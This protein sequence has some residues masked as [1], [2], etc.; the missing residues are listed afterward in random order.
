MRPFLCTARPSIHT[1]PTVVVGRGASHGVPACVCAQAAGA[2]FMGTPSQP[3]SGALE[4]E[5]MAGNRVYLQVRACE[6]V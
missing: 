6:C 5:V 2:R 1:T 3:A 4:Q